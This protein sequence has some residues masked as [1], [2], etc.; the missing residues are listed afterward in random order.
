MAVARSGRHAAPSTRGRHAA[1]STPRTPRQPVGA[2][3]LGVT[4]GA[5]G[6]VALLPS[7]GTAA[8]P[9][10]PSTASAP[11]QVAAAAVPPRQLRTVVRA[12]RARAVAPVAQVAAPTPVA[13]P[14]PP[15]APAPR[16]APVDVLPGCTVGRDD[17]ARHPNGQIPRRALCELPGHGGHALRADAARAFVRLDLAHRAAFGTGLCVTDSYRSLSAQRALAR[18]KPRLAGRPGRSEHGFGVAVDLACGAESFGTRTHRWLEA[19]AGEHGWYQ[20]SW[21][22]RGGSKPEPWHWELQD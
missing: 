7:A 6:L 16:P 13:S 19:R 4:A 9:A 15:P 18:S 1:R 5:F 2:V 11:Q 8:A 14:A 10:G 20:P 21:A 12:S 17:A 22:R 3:L